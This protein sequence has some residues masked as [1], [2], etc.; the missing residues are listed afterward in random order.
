MKKFILILI[1]LAIL[2]VIPTA[3]VGKV[4]KGVS[5]KALHLYSPEIVT[6][7]GDVI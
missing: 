3:T 2:L 5:A 4:D 6:I 1:V 7:H